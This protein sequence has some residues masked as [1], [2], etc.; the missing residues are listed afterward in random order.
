M[1]PQEAIV[2]RDAYVAQFKAELPAT[3]RVLAAVPAD[4]S[5]YTPD[6]KS[7]TAIDLAWHIAS[8]D[9]W[10]LNSIAAGQFNWDPEAAKRPK[11]MTGGADVAAFYEPAFAKGIA[12]VEASSGEHHI[13]ELDFIG[14]MPLV[15][16]LGFALRHS[17]HHRGQL[18]AYL[19]PMGSKVP[20]IY[21]P[22]A[23]E[24]QNASSEA[25]A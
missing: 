10:F 21:G 2:L 4:R 17:I 18:S 23:D 24:P 20:S 11:T 12:Q 3:L 7:M 16:I 13:T 9:I 6:P 15:D 25:S 14:K 22:S 5:A 8:S 1:Q 19:R